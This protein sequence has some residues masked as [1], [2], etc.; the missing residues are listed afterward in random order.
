MDED[1][2]K[3]HLSINEVAELTLKQAEEIL[4]K[5]TKWVKQAEKEVAE[6]KAKETVEEVEQTN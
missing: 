6:A 5:S 2:I 4:K 3:G 1:A